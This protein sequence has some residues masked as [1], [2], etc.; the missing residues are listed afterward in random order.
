MP[1]ASSKR[2][3]ILARLFTTLLLCSLHSMWLPGSGLGNASSQ[4]TRGNQVTVVRPLIYP[5]AE[6]PLKSLSQ[7]DIRSTTE[8]QN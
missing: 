3:D 5:Q 8:A 7:S 2:S 6:N 1:D 4:S